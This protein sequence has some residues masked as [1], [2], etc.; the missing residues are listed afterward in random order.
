[1]RHPALDGRV[2]SVIA[3]TFLGEAL[4]MARD[5]DSRNVWEDEL[6]AEQPQ[7]MS[8]SSAGVLERFRNAPWVKEHP[9]LLKGIAVG[10]SLLLMAVLLAWQ[11]RWFEATE[12]PAPA[13]AARPQPGAEQRQP[14]AGGQPMPSAA[15]TSPAAKSPETPKT[16]EKN[17]PKPTEQQNVK[18]EATP[19]PDDVSRWKK[20]DYFRARLENN[21]KLVEA[22]ARLGE[23]TRGSVAAAQG[24][25]ALLVPPPPL[26]PPSACTA[27]NGGG[28]NGSQANS[29]SRR[30]G[31]A[32]RAGAPGSAVAA[33]G[34]PPP[35]VVPPP[36]PRTPAEAQ[37]LVETIVA[38]L[39]ENG[40]AFAQ[41]ATRTDPF[42]RCP[43]TT[44]RRRLR[45]S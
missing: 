16:A 13:V 5:R 31:A 23:N 25:A 44:T 43:R 38:A 34:Q 7:P 26:P 11:M 24:L 41:K 36:K 28:S 18:L 8:T 17:P 9:N 29:N 22:V 30:R 1:M 39:G 3:T 10:V 4:S 40:T 12:E 19:L 42:R 14:Q 32:S 45:P 2:A 35:A 27:G 37:K 20:E 6:E 21:P 33:P 15:T